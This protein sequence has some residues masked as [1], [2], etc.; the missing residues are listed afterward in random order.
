ML[1]HCH[2]LTR[3]LKKHRSIL[4][5][6]LPNI[7]FS[8]TRLNFNP[9]AK[10]LIFLVLTG[11]FLTTSQLR[12]ETSNA[13]STGKPS[14]SLKIG[15]VPY[16]ASSQAVAAWLPLAS[17]L[18]KKLQQS[19]LIVS[20]P[21][22][23]IFHQRIQQGRYFLIGST[24]HIAA[25]MIKQNQA[26]PVRLITA[27]ITGRLVVRDGS[28]FSNLKTLAGKS[29]T[30]TAVGSFTALLLEREIEI[31]NQQQPFSINIRYSSSHATALRNLLN[32]QTDAA[33]VSKLPHTTSTVDQFSNLNI[34]GHSSLTSYPMIITPTALGAEHAVIMGK[35]LD[36]F[37]KMNALATSTLNPFNSELRHEF[38]VIK[39]ADLDILEPLISAR[40]P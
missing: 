34:I 30:T 19:V 20:A 28:S 10:E 9:L 2:R 37:S 25:S 11:V 8:P 6:H 36:E 21:S 33:F 39:Q 16:S 24:P 12:A 23:K 14:T 38:A 17:F 1:K 3:K 22:H 27:P 26:Y 35:L 18:Q 4:S 7:A 31:L 13:A 40:Q 15:L 32:D 5:C 29:I